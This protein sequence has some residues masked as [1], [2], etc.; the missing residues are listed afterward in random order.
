MSDASVYRVLCGCLCMFFFCL[1]FCAC[2]QA[3]MWGWKLLKCT[4]EILFVVSLIAF[5]V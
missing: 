2:L 1:F 5:H 4:I 3:D